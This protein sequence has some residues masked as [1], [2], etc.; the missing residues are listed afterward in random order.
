MLW[1]GLRFLSLQCIGS[2]VV[3]GHP[4]SHQDSRAVMP[5]QRFLW[6]GLSIGLAG[7]REP[8]WGISKADH[9][10]WLAQHLNHGGCSLNVSLLS[11]P[12]PL[13]EP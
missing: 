13:W 12:A 5:S 1:P 6:E 4:L 2:G 10:L 11:L 9:V 3:A 8:H 7:E